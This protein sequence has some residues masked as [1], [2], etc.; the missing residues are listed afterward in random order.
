M[1]L[2]DVL[3]LLTAVKYD[4]YHVEVDAVPLNIS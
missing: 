1:N 2:T 3:F 4:F